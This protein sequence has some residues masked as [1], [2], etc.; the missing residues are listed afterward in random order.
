MRWMLRLLAL[1]SFCIGVGTFHAQSPDDTV[2][3][4]P[5]VNNRWGIVEGFW[6]PDLVCELGVG[7]ERIIFDWSQHQP[8]S[9]EDWNTLNVDDQWLKA[10]HAC[11]R[12]IV[13]LLKN[14]PAWATDG[15]AGIGVPRG[16]YLASDDPANLWAAFVRRTVDYYASR[17]VNHFIIW[18]EPDI[19]AGT[20][21]Y[22]FEGSLDD[23]VQLVAV[24]Y[25]VAKQTNPAA[26]IHLAGTTYW[27]DVNEG[28]APY[29]ER[30]MDALAAHPQGAQNAYFFDVM[31]LH[32]YFRSQTVYDLVRGVREMMQTHGVGNK[33]V[34]INETNAAP[35]DDPEWQVNRPQFPLDL[36]QQASFLM[37]SAVLGLA[38]GADRIAAYKLYDQN[39]PAGAESFGLLNPASAAPRPAFYAWRTVV[40]TLSDVTHAQLAQTDT[41]DAVL[42]RHEGGTRHTWA[43]WSR[44]ARPAQVSI[45]ATSTKAY[46]VDVT[47]NLQ[48]LT[49][50]QGSYRLTLPPADCSDPQEGCFIGGEPLLFIQLAD[51]SSATELTSGGQSNLTFD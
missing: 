17:G 19:Q 38:A 14:T 15:T 8:E 29:F 2:A 11:G 20:Y 35:T 28:R 1:W 36:R 42:M 4:F 33:P 47:G 22:E 12:E 50:S 7:W 13:A 49:P 6:F 40:R 10:A 32:I 26:V 46:L 18:N 9:A 34:W 23:Y 16:L 39:L 25:Q 44:T 3:S 30:L 43:L 41:L 31:S 45:S 21:G 51:S 37:Q 27:H 5:S 48:V 24:A